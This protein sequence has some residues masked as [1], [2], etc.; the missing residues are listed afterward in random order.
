MSTSINVECIKVN[1]LPVY[2]AI[3]NTLKMFNR[4]NNTENRNHIKALCCKNN[5]R[6][7]D[8]F[9][10]YCQSVYY[11][12]SLSSLSAVIYEYVKFREQTEQLNSKIKQK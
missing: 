5:E 1:S 2:L 4:T 10:D 12:H 6:F 9:C 8:T 11:N 3:S 7:T